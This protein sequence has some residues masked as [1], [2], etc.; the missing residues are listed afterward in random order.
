MIRK[1]K[2][3]CVLTAQVKTKV[4]KVCATIIR[5]QLN[6]IREITVQPV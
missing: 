1:S 2:K 5:V 4:K 3:N 6:I